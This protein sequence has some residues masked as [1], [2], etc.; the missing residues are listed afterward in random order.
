MHNCGIDSGKL[1]ELRVH[2]GTVVSQITENLTIG[3]TACSGLEQRK[4]QNF[5][6]MFLNGRHTPADILHKVRNMGRVSM[7]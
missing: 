2:M 3:S 6:S 4:H 1:A 7:S 5:T